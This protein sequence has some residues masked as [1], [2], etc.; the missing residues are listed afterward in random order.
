MNRRLKGLSD[1]QG[2]SH[3]RDRFMKTLTSW[4]YNKM[5]DY[6]VLAQRVGVTRTNSFGII[7]K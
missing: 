3:I 6:V 7:G 2:F 1:G 5:D 4:K